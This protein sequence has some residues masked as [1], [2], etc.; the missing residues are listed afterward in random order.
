MPNP[1]YAYRPIVDRGGM[2]WPADRKMAFY[3]E[4]NIE[5]F[6]P[7][8]PSVGYFPTMALPMDPIN[9]GWRDYGPRIGVW[10]IIEAMDRLEL[11]VSAALNSSTCVAYPQIVEAGVKRGWSWLAHGITNSQMWNDLELADEGVLLDRV[12]ADIEKATGRPPR[13]WIGPGL[14]ETP[15]TLALL[16]PRGFTYTLDWPADDQPFPLLVDGQR[17]VSVPFSTEIND[18]AAFVVWHW[19]P[20]QFADAMLEQFNRMYRE[21]QTRPGTVMSLALHPF[22]WTP[23]RS[24][25]IEE[26]LNKIRAHDDVWFPTSEEIADYYLENYYDSY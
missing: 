13:G 8:V 10:R 26:V 9:Q 2:C 14:T 20:A 18:I 6:E 21:A 19:T 1:P 16:G 4:L 7:G 11:P 23:F 15:N 5:R 12:V 3:V 25:P 17:M 24:G 22:L